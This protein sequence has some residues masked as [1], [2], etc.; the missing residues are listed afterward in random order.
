M[1]WVPTKTKPN[2]AI[3]FKLRE[4]GPWEAVEVSTS[5]CKAKGKILNGWITKNSNNHK[6]LT[7]FSRTAEWKII[8][9]IPR[10]SNIWPAAHNKRELVDNLLMIKCKHGVN[11]V[12]NIHVVKKKRL[13][14]AKKSIGKIKLGQN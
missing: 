2:V 7:D 9:E 1:K 13:P 10:L 14:T 3:L 5:T 12:E 8:E 6:Q 11:N 4:N